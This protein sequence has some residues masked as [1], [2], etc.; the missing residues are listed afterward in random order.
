MVKSIE[1]QNQI[2]EAISFLLDEM[3]AKDLLNI[4]SKSMVMIKPNICL[5][6][7]HE[8]GAT[9]NPYVVQC[10]VDWL[11]ENYDI[12]KI[13]IGEAD[14]TM[15]NVSVAFKALGWGEIF[16]D[17]P[18]VELLNL[19][20][21]DLLVTSLDDGFYFDQLEMSKKYME[22]DFLIS[23]GKLKT[24]TMTSISCILK[25]QFGANPV[26]YKLK[27]HDS[28]DEVI[29]DLNMVRMP[30]LCLVDGI[31]AMEGEGP[32]LGIPKVM[33]LLIMGNDAVAVDHACSRIMKI[34]PK[35]A[36]HLNLA[37]KKNLGSFNYQVFGSSIE[38]IQS[39]FETISVWKNFIT[40]AYMSNGLQKIPLWKGL[41]TKIF[42][43]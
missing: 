21:D 41:F 20:R 14:A 39:R 27:Y 15:L 6:R 24:H 9:V 7:T 17:Y 31:I 37:E 10:L 28:L 18:N 38:E 19:S 35:K 23:V 16:K 2:N 4:P 11:L 36:R 22:A 1:N 34:N 25:N 8:T 29:C 33:N 3:K 40:K 30:D 13:Y 26:P 42:G 43:K 32:V 12:N 5:V